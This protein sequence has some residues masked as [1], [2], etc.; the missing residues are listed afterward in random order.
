MNR[1]IKRIVA[2]FLLTIVL[3]LSVVIYA[4]NSGTIVYIGPYS[5]SYHRAVC[6]YLDDPSPITLSEATARGLSPCSRCKPPRLDTSKSDD[7]SPYVIPDSHRNFYG[8][9]ARGGSSGGGFAVIVTIV[10]AI[11]GIRA[12]SHIGRTSTQTAPSTKVTPTANPITKPGPAPTP[13]QPPQPSSRP[14]PQP[15]STP[16]TI[17]CPKCGAKMQLRTG[18]YGKFYGCTNFP[19]CRGSRDYVAKQ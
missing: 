12:V 2:L 16:N 18:R 5:G 10:L 7:N 17:R 11:M 8:A 14:S 1:H 6:T 13:I 4:D 9:S 19:Q 15:P 3:P